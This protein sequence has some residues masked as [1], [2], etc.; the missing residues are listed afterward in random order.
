M[1]SKFFSKVF[2]AAVIAITGY[3]VGSRTGKEI[4]QV[5]VQAVPTVEA[6]K[7]TGTDDI[8][9]IISIVTIILVVILL[10]LKA[11]KCALNVARAVE[12]NNN[13]NSGEA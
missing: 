12:N 1:A 7:T 2:N 13:N 5:P 9:V 11:C 4:V 3:E 10:I 6:I 8:V